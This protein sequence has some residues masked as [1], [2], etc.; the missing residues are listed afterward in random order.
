MKRINIGID[1][2]KLKLDICILDGEKEE[3]H[4]ILNKENS[5]KDFL[6]YLEDVYSQK[7]LYFGYEATNNYMR[8]LQVI[9]DD[10]GYK[11]IMINPHT[12]HHY[13][14]YIGLKEKTDKSDSYGIALF[15]SEKNDD[16][17]DSDIDYKLKNK[18]KDYVTTIELL[19]KMKTQVKNLIKSK[20]DLF[21][22][23]LK[24]RLK[25]IE[26]EINDIENKLKEI[27][28]KKMYSDFKE[29]KIIK[30]QIKGI[31]DYTLLVL[32]PIIATAKN[33]TIKQIQAYIGLNPIRYESGSS[34]YK[35][36]KIS[37]KGYG[38]ARKVLYMSSMVAIRVNE[39]IKEKFERLVKAGKK[40]RVALVA[41]MVHLLRAIYFQ[42][43]KLT[44]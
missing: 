34:V 24:E 1:V 19:N 8:L 21:D 39:I 12:L 27:S 16:D 13:F 7:E 17:F 26:K 20:L 43:H 38:L 18:Y 3:Y 9:L 22:D 33:K 5:I 2:S 44:I 28:Y 10:R 36:P 35:K 30:E 14:K 11:N 4:T 41:C 37:K 29:A 6:D 42:Y 15:V 40:K 32:L 31:G 25:D 23:Y